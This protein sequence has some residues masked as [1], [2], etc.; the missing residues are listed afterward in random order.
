MVPAG[1]TGPVNQAHK[2]VWIQTHSLHLTFKILK[3]E[4]QLGSLNLQSKINSNSSKR[5]RKKASRAEDKDRKGPKPEAATAHWTSERD[6]I[7]ICHM[8]QFKVLPLN[9]RD[10]GGVPSFLCKYPNPQIPIHLSKSCTK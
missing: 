3:T 2:Q 1:Q 6:E 4:N 8:P 10:W 5:N 7:L 9:V